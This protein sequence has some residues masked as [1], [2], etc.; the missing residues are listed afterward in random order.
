[1]PDAT[2]VKI[3]PGTA[4]AARSVQLTPVTLARTM[5]AAREPKGPLMTTAGHRAP[6][7][8]IIPPATMRKVMAISTFST[9]DVPNI[10]PK[11]L[12]MMPAVMYFLKPKQAQISTAIGAES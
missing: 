3:I 8:A 1:M 6:Q 11:R 9:E 7:S 10:I 4:A 12:A 5:R 2:A